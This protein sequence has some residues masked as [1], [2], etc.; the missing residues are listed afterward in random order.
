V[1][2]QIQVAE[3]LMVG[4]TSKAI[5]YRDVQINPGDGCLRFH[6]IQDEQEILDIIPLQQIRRVIVYKEEA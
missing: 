6:Y 4:S 5:V 2:E 3:V 1:S